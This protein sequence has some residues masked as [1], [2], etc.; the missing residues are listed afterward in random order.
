MF[1]I[2]LPLGFDPASWGWVQSPG[3]VW[4]RWEIPYRYPACL[5]YC[6]PAG[7]VAWYGHGRYEG[8]DEPL[9]VEADA[10][11]T[12]ICTGIPADPAHVHVRNPRS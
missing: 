9:A 12:E 3:G 10:L 6:T 4:L 7:C 5:G 8:R 2:E 1:L 11:L